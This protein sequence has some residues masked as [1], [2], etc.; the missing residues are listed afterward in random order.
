MIVVV[1]VVYMFKKIINLDIVKETYAFFPFFFQTYTFP[2]KLRNVLLCDKVIFNFLFDPF[3][4]KCSLITSSFVYVV[5]NNLKGN[6]IKCFIFFTN[7]S[8]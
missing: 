3:K 1:I 6:D 2:F 7:F 5:F 8:K 4:I